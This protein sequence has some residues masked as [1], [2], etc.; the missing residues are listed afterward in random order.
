MSF[1]PLRLQ[2]FAPLLAVCLAA[3]LSACASHQTEPPDVSAAEDASFRQ[4]P[5]PAPAV[6]SNWWRGFDDAALMALVQRAQSANH[7]VR[8]AVQR[9]RQ[10][11]AGQTAVASRLWPTV[12]L[13]GSAS[14]ERSGLPEQVKQGKPDTRA[15]RGALDLGWELD[16][17][18]AARAGADA[19]ELDALTAE[20][21]VDTA[22]WL[23]SSEVARQYIVWQSARL[24]LA[25]LDALLKAQADT[26]RLTR[27]REA[28]G[29][30]SRFD[31]ARAAGEVQALAAQ[32][33]PLRTLVAVT[34][35]QLAVLVGANPNRPLT[36]LDVSTAPWLPTPPRL[37]AR[38]PVDLLMRR[39]DLRVAQKLFMAEAARLRE[40]QA[41]RWPKFFLAA[42]FGRQDLRLNA[43]DLSPVRYSTAA[44]AFTMPLF[45]AGRL[46]AAVE[47]QSAKERMAT[48]QYEKAV[49]GAVK[50]VDDSL[51][52]LAQ[53]R[54]RSAALDATT[55]QRRTGLRHAESLYREGQIDLLQL[56]DAQRAVIA[57]ELS[58]IDGQAQL[59][60]NTVQ[61]ASALGGGWQDMPAAVTSNTHTS[62]TTPSLAPESLP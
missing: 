10:A 8:I 46:R 9:V 7:D 54:D 44:L 22:R 11:R 38:Q 12:S 42:A 17:F 36:E 41:D 30:A 31:V 28:A 59:A 1:S 35:T 51:V 37:S 58:A 49:L 25:K 2:P 24:R 56:L 15:Y 32:L 62:T 45:D 20:E 48:L 23:V 6:E 57:A 34:E 52:A 33:P 21:G 29:L 60:L 39:P 55:Q 13:T 5:D 14:D 40:A 43:L 18:G 19:A 61:L 3:L 4:A 50:D 47:R 53:E 26:E 16:V 27:S